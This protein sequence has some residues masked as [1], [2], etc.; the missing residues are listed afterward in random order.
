MIAYCGPGRA[1]AT[2]F[3]LALDGE[4]VDAIEETPHLPDPDM[5]LLVNPAVFDLPPWPDFRDGFR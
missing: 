4:T 1:A 2:A 3:I 5:I